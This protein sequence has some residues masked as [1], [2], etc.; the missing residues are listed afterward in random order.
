M[1]IPKTLKLR[2]LSVYTTVTN[3]LDDATDKL[4]TK[5]D[6]KS[7]KPRRDWAALFWVRRRGEWMLAR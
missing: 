2:M 5:L 3:E 4:K 6:R 7:R 1:P